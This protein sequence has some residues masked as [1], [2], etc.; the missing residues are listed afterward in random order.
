MTMAAEPNSAPAGSAPAATASAPVAEDVYRGELVSFPWPWAFQIHKSAAI[1]VSDEQLEQLADPDRKVNLSLGP[2]PHE[3]SLRQICERAK[4]GGQRTLIIAFDHFFAQYRPGQGDK[5]RQLTP[6]KEEYV[7][8]I[9]AIS[10]FIQP[11]G[12]GLEL[13]LLT[14]LEIGPAYTAE[15]G[16]HGLW[17]HYRKGLRDPRT[18]AYSVQFW[19]QTRWAN[20]KG[21]I[22]IEDAGVRVFAFR[23]QRLHGTSY[24]HVDPQSIVE[25]TRTAQVEV[26]PGTKQPSQA[27]RIRVY[28]TG[29]ADA[30]GLDRVL[31]VQMYKT[32]EM[33][34]FSDKALPYLKKLVDRYV[35]AGVKLNGLYSDE[36]HIQQDWGY[37]NH[38]DHGEFAVRYVS[39]TLA[40]RFAELYGRQYR[41]FAKYLVYFTYGQE[42]FATNLSA[43]DRLMHVFSPTPEGIRETA[44]FRSRYYKFLQDGVV[45]LFAQAKRYLEGRL[46]HRLEARA[47]ATWAESPT[48]DLWSH[49]E[50]SYEYTPGFVWSNTVQ[51]AASACHD[52]FK[53][54]DFLTGN[55]N[56]H[57]EGGWLDRN[58]AGLALAAS[59]G[60]LN[61]V[62]YSYGAHW[63]MPGEVS[64]R[65]SALM[66][67]SG[68]GTMAPCAMVQGM[69]HRDVEVLML[70][71]LDLVATEE[72]FGS[73]MSQYA[74]ANQVT[75]AKL[76]ERGRVVRGAIEMAGRRFTTLVAQFEPF[77]DRRLLEM[78]RQLAEQ[79]GRV[80]WSGPPP[81]L[82]ADG[83]SIL[84]A[85]Q[86]LFGVTYAP[87]RDEGIAAPGQEVRFEGPLADLP[88]MTILTNFLVDRI[89]PIEPREAA[90][91][92]GSS[93]PKVAARVKDRAVA[94]HRDLPGGGS[95]TALGFRPRDD[96]SASLGY[97]ARWWFETLLRLG[98]YPPTGQFAGINDNTEYLSRT[99]DYLV[100]RFPNGAIALAPHLRDLEE[101]WS[102][103]FARDPEK[104]KEIV[105]KLKL[106]SQHISLKDFKVAGRS[107]TYEGEQVV[108]F[109]ADGKGV[110]IAF[111]GVGSRQ[112]TIDGRTTQFADQP[113]AVA[114]APIDPARRVKHG[115]VMQILAHGSGE[116]RIPVLLQADRVDLVREGPTL[117][118]R[119]EL[120][121]SRIEGDF[122]TF[123]AAPGKMYLVPRKPDR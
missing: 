80:V 68:A 50:S 45:D 3:L 57:A 52:Y 87:G 97:D 20:N 26:W 34:Y 41:D 30:P 93:R 116:L 1:L 37:H 102:G 92:L 74:Y 7:R 51:Q 64:L 76:L 91:G 61:D 65:R 107:V 60:I 106:P 67:A 71:P 40:A 84:A 119:G 118:S 113:I 66:D 112:I 72:R 85:W 4:A 31:V 28:G 29:V 14:P 54:G 69:Q 24:I 53:W 43:K 86:D 5:P 79:G 94:I 56:D 48:C 123:T 95:F 111:C 36:M 99:T 10:R 63:G 42:D 16:E 39:P 108:A 90:D 109:R 2:N 120:V 104:D 105:A 27:V 12:L 22:D 75:Q 47:H 11:Y 117:G 83:T 9:A 98:A 55:G 58:Y 115:A 70:Y 103:G 122:L 49:G 44:L 38:H 88:P 73:W 8:L 35:D 110:P 13:S 96:Q 101:S 33:D 121:P 114:W 25:I 23:E 82:A 19:R 17:M 59:T 32:P 78:M 89:Y 100:C 46:G 15:T 21:V 18:G 81:V 62:P 77:P 6:D